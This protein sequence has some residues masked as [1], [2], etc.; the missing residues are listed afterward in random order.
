MKNCQHC[1]TQPVDDATQC[2]RCGAAIR[3]STNP[4]ADQPLPTPNGPAYY[5]PHP[6]PNTMDDP[7]MSWVIPVHNPVLAVISSYCG[8]IGLGCPILGP[9][10]VITGI[11]AVQQI[12]KTPGLTG[13]G[14][15]IF[16]IVSGV[17]GS[18]VLLIVIFALIAGS[19]S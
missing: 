7:A 5:P 18:L 15:S 2:P 4:F 14:R 1:G 6:L 16:G 13:M 12:R 17:I 10:A 19:L 8:L 11:L 3:R 9:V